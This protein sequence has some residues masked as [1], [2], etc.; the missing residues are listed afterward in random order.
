MMGNGNSHTSCN[1]ND[2][3]SFISDEK[4]RFGIHMDTSS[5]KVYNEELHD[6]LI[7]YTQ[8]IGRWNKKK[9]QIIQNDKGDVFV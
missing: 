4:S 5:A 9:V 1:G 2:A 8:T 6:L 3:R 7:T